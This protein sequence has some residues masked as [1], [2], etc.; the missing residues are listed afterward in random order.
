MFFWVLL[1]RSS[2][3]DIL[4]FDFFTG[5]YVQNMCFG[6][7][8]EPCEENFPSCVGKENGTIEYS[9]DEDGSTKYIACFKERTVGQMTCKSGTFDRKTKKCVDPV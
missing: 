6:D 8:C 9:K 2:I 7:S 5:E 3:S 1:R 4:Y